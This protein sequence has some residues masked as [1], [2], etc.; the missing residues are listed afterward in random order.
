MLSHTFSFWATELEVQFD[1]GSI[2]IAQMLRRAP[3]RD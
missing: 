3:P 2:V 1:G